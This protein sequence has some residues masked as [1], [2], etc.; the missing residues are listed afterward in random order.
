M[1]A[2]LEKAAKIKLLILDVDGVFTNGLL[3][4]SESGDEYK[5][6]HTQDGLGIKLLLKTGV[7][8][9]IISARE[10]SIVKKRMSN[11]GIKH[12][13]LGDRPKIISYEALI[14]HLNVTDEQVA[15][16]GDDL[17]DLGLIRRVGLGIA[18]PNAVEQVRQ[19]AKWQTKTP[20]GLGAV[21]E[22]C[23]LIMTAHNTL[24]EIVEKHL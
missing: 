7:D 12:I 9:G 5:A 22:V 13:Y 14:K 8:I 20:G 10:S 23:E 11:L 1:K 21:R 4:L 16:V 18:V 19:H 24:D 17:T 3:F 6:F 2:I 15:Y